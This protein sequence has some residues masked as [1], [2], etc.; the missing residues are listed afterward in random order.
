MCTKI[1][2]ILRIWEKI[3][4]CPEHVNYHHSPLYVSRDVSYSVHDGE[5]TDSRI[6][7][8]VEP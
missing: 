7:Y 4:T 8:D 2:E 5:G 3:S 6:L 1:Y